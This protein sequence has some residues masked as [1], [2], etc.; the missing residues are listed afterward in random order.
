[1]ADAAHDTIKIYEGF[2]GLETQLIAAVNPRN[3]VKLKGGC[4]P[5]PPRVEGA[6][7]G[8]RSRDSMVP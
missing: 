5:R 6:E 8:P 7:L 2:A 3:N 1:M 4:R